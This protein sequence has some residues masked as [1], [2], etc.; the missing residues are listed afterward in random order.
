MYYILDRDGRVVGSADGPPDSDDL[1]SRGERAVPSTLDLPPFRVEVH[2]FPDR[3]TVVEI[4]APA[5]G[6][7]IVLTTSAEDRDGDGIPDLPANGR[8]RVT[9]TATLQ[10]QAG[11]VVA[12]P[13]EVYF[14]TSAGTLSHRSVTTEE[15]QASVRLTSSRETVTAAVSATAAGYTPARLELEFAP[16]GT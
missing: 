9:I 7:A 5:A 15:G 13:V 2:G 8:S 10:D 11:N 4:A 6:P 1:A 16:V 14:R 12:E 3:P